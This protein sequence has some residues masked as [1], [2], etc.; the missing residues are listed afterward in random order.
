MKKL[1]KRTF[2][3]LGFFVVALFLTAFIW[4]NWE[5]PTPGQQAEIVDFLQYDVQRIDD[6]NR[7]AHMRQTLLHIAGVHGSTYNPASRLLVV[8]YGVEETT[9]EAIEAKIQEV[10]NIHLKEKIFEK[11]GP[12]CPIN[13]AYITRVKRFLCIR[14]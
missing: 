9:R 12:R 10:Y 13:V 4:A 14:D 11:S 8:S 7:I 3:I 5:K 2:T 6:S 1:I